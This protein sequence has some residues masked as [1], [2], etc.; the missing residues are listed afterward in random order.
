MKRILSLVLSVF[1]MAGLLLANATTVSAESDFVI[2]DECVE[3]LKELEGFDRYP[4]WDY[5]QWTV[6]HGSRCPDEDLERYRANGI[7]YEEADVLLRQ[8]AANFSKSINS[9]IDKFQLNYTQ[10]QFDALLLFTYN[11]GNAWIFREGSFRAGL[12]QG[13]TGND[14]L[15]EIGQW[16]HAGGKIL[17]PLISRR[18]IETNVFFNGVYSRKV[19]DNYCYVIL[20]FNGGEGETDVQA[21]DSDLPAEEI[22]V[23]PTREGYIFA[24]WYTANEGGIK[25]TTL[26]RSLRNMTLYA[27]WVEDENA[28]IKDDPAPEAPEQPSTIDP[29]KVT[30][31]ATDVNIRTGPGTNYSRVDCVSKGTTM[32][33]TEVKTGTGY[34]WGKFGTDRWIALMYT[35]YDEVVKQNTEKPT[36]PETQPTEPETKPTEP[37]TQPTEPETQPTEPETQPT[38]PE[39]KPTEPETQPTEPETQPTEPEE[40][41]GIMGTVTGS[42]LRIRSGAGTNYSILGFLQIGDRVTITERKTVG[43]MEWG[44]MEK[45]WISLTYVKLDQ[46]AQEEKPQEPAPEQPKPTEPETQPTEPETKPAEMTGTVKVNDFLRIRSGAGLGNSIVGYYGPNDKVT[47]LETKTVSGMKWGRTDR[48]W[49]SMDYVVLDNQS[50]SPE[51]PQ[52][53]PNVI[54]GTVNVNDFLRIR[55]GAGLD[56]KIVGFLSPNERVTI[57]DTKTVNGT[58]WGKISSGW[59]SMDYVI[60]D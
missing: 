50:Q 37:E 49:I 1:L 39:T 20:E 2:S 7:T 40:P 25:V 11:F 19:L 8:H 43:S 12:I 31:T 33:I 46:P 21:Y 30:V 10:N 26:D 15:Y 28:E 38:E 27:R 35:N 55:S 16:C 52:E 58:K 34:T 56:Y 3:L 9:F 24:G 23:I 29:V 36:E 48:G 59:I 47:I 60:V 18:L 44:K 14:F 51:K 6:G 13:V 53:T 42:D 4:R 57:T 5:S 17:K 54:T 41:T 22:R 32:T 45:G